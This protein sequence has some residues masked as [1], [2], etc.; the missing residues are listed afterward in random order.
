MFQFMAAFVP[1]GKHI[2]LFDC[3]GF[4]NHDELSYW[5]ELC[6]T[7]TYLIFLN[8]VLFITDESS[9]SH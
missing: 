7:I 8:S 5:R 2:A 3:F 4:W 9:I 1:S 6:E